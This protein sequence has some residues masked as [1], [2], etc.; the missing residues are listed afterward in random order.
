[1]RSSLC[2]GVF[3]FLSATMVLAVGPSRKD[4]ELITAKVEDFSLGKSVPGVLDLKDS[5]SRELLANED[6]KVFG[7]IG[8]TGTQGRVAAFSHGSFL[9]PGALMEQAGAKHL[10]A[11]TIRWAGRS[12]RPSVGL[13][14]SL[15]S[16]A[17]IL[18]DLGMNVREL[19]PEDLINQVDVYCFIGHEALSEEGVESVR[20]FALKGSGVII[21][22]TPWPFANK[23]PDFATFPGNQVGSLAGITFRP[24]GYASVRENIAFGPTPVDDSGVPLPIAAAR[25]LTENRGKSATPKLINDLKSGF[26]LKNEELDSFLEA[27]AELESAIGPIV[28]T[29]ENPIVPGDDPL[30]DT[31][32]ELMDQF[33]QLLPA[34]KVRPIAAAQD[35]PGAIPDDAPRVTRTITVDGNYKGWL[36]GR[37]AGANN[38]KE[39]RPT[40]LYAAPGELI[41]VT[42]PGRIADNGFEVVIGAYRGGLKNRDKWQRWPR[43]QRSV[44]IKS[45]ETTAANGLGGL[46]TLRVPRDAEF[47]NVEFQIEG[48]VEAP[49]YVHG[50]TSLLDWKA[51]VRKR[52]APWAELASERMIIAIP[53]DY[54]RNLNN[55]GEV[56]EIWNAFIDTAAELVVVDR[57]DYR[58]ERIVFDRQTAAGSMHS[59]YPVAAHLGKSAEQAVDASSLKRDGNWGFFHEYGHNHQHNLWSLPNTGETTCNLWSVYIYEEY[60]GKHR[61]KTHG[62]INPLKRQQLRNAY[63]NGGRNFASE[64]AVWTALDSY[65]LIQEEFGW[66]PFKAVFDEYNRLPQDDWPSSQQEKNDQWV[67]RLSKACNADLAPYYAAWNLPLSE[68]VS[69]E[70]SELPAWDDHPVKRYL[71]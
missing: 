14:P 49:L 45:R 8:L 66:E 10:V 63:F 42:V 9:K 47:G 55:P 31:V 41:R 34:E 30:V 62:G 19:K 2:Q 58:A 39:M 22:A 32:I 15:N 28:P 50:Q 43:L 7:A 26:R 46:I 17:P 70:T 18:K 54:I 1:M 60:I 35:Y 68:F 29:K 67:I 21:A 52:P 23:F 27:L 53:S 24:D 3:W 20:R 6:G 36:S 71:R 33:N 5:S 69:Q 51:E 13:S 40:G 44:E 56:M 12:T 16:L 57:N 61:D 37:G 11:N 25:K 38:A 65:L 48:A 4:I 64:W 59:G